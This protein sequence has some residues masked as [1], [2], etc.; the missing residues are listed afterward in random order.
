M[1][2]VNGIFEMLKLNKPADLRKY[3]RFYFICLLICILSFIVLISNELTN[4][5]DGMWVGSYYREYGWV[6]STGR[7]VWPIIGYMRNHLSPEPFTSILALAVYV[8]AGCLIISI[9]KLWEKWQAYLIMMFLFVNTA[10][11]SDLSYRFISPTYAASFLFGVLAFWLLANSKTVFGIIVSSVCLVGCLGCYQNNLG[12]FCILAIV[13]IIS[14]LLNKE[15]YDDIFKIVFRSAA[16][17]LTGCISYKIIWDV[18]M[19]FRHAKASSYKGADEISLL[20]IIYMFPQRVKVAYFHFLKYFSGK[21]LFHNAFQNTIFYSLAY[22]SII[23]MFI[24]FVILILKKDI[25]RSA[26]CFFLIL[27][28]P[29]GA[30]IA[31]ILAPTGGGVMIHMTHPLIMSPGLIFCLMFCERFQKSFSKVPGKMLLITAS[32][33]CLFL[34]YGNF[35]QTS[36]DQEVMLTSRNTTQ[37]FMNRVFSDM[38]RRNENTDLSEPVIFVG[39]PS[40]NPHFLKGFKLYSKK[41]GANS[42]PGRATASLWNISNSYTHYGEFWMDVDGNCGFQSYVG[43]LRDCGVYY[44]VTKERAVWKDICSRDEVTAMPAYPYEGYIT[45][46]DGYTVI[47]IS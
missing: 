8:F 10:V 42:G 2:S 7:Y 28:I 5:Y 11:L 24:A 22:L 6:I 16:S 9:F 40:D 19:K 44:E 43:L 4:T 35:L 36:I 45:H 12:C 15:E 46:I 18:G 21:G 31:L 17:F 33:I 23:C 29:L 47:K 38:E 30:N 37:L 27:L 41:E 14:A 13:Y 39:R 1:A 25:I 34:V 26:L 32:L 3:I 20:S